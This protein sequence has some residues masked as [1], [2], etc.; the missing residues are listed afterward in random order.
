MSENIT[1]NT[2]YFPKE[3]YQ[4][5]PLPKMCGNEPWWPCFH[6]GVSIFF[7]T[8]F[9]SVFLSRGYFPV[10]CVSKSEFGWWP[11]S[12]SLS[13]PWCGRFCPGWTPLCCPK[14]GHC[15]SKLCQSRIVI[16]HEPPW[17]M[18]LSTET[19]YQ[20]RCPP[21]PKRGSPKFVESLLKKKNNNNIMRVPFFYFP[22]QDMASPTMDFLHIVE[23]PSTLEPLNLMLGWSMVSNNVFVLILRKEQNI[24][25]QK[26]YYHNLS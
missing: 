12:V 19:P 9:G 11:L 15:L 21:T 26:V 14:P 24:W 13:S 7:C 20:P 5:M 25:C 4:S 8:L 16:I 23:L 6:W 22:F 3:F 17:C 18:L 10:F 1:S 2:S